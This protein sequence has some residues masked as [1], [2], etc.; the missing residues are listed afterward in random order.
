M[1][2]GKEVECVCSAVVYRPSEG[3]SGG[4]LVGV[5]S[6]GWLEGGSGERAGG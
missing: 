2:E 6:S 5:Y 3:A 4:V 1:L